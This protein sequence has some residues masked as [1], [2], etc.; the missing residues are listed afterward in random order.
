MNE[1]EK[2]RMDLLGSKAVQKYQKKNDIIILP[3][4]CV[5]MHGPD[6]PLG[7]DTIHA[8]ASSIVLAKEWK[9]LV[10]PPI[11]YVYP[12]ASGPW[13]GTV[14]IMPEISQEYIKSV[15][16]A[17]IKNGFK[18]VILY[19]THGP[20]SSMFTVVIRSIFNESED[21]VAGLM[22]NIMPEDIMKEK[23]GYTRGEDV[24][25]LSSLKILGHHGVYDPKSKADKPPEFPFKV[26]GDLKKFGGSGMVPWLFK[27][28]HQHAGFRKCV[29]MNDADKG[30]AVMKLTA[31]RMRKFPQAFKTYQ[32]Q[33]KKL[34]KDK[35]WLKDTVWSQ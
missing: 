16:K 14:N 28:D 19:G 9:C 33:M 4:G 8:W 20:L 32:N 7:C 6:I 18:R 23:L 10:A 5:E 15:V 22:S 34:M 27:A 21:V 31:K 13:P 35:P 24:L 1:Y 30:I 29:R 17:L 25:V 11:Y 12:G 2:V 3:V 26:I